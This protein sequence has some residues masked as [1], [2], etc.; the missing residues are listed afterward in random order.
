MKRRL[1]KQFF[2]ICHNIRSTYNV[3]SI[4]R[5]ADAVRINK[6]YLCGYTSAPPNEKIAKVA[7][8]AEK[9]VPFESV[10]SAV[11]LIKKLKSNGVKI[12]ALENNIKQGTRS[13]TKFGVG[14]N[15]LKFKPKFPLALVLGNEVEG[16]PKSILNLA[17]KIIYL[18]M[19]G[20]KES[21]NV[22]VAFGI[23][24]YEIKK[25]L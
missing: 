22:S 12:I 23:A 3:G 24:A 13:H 19:F 2:V 15:Y 16:L 11:G 20:A 25:F 1:D 4:F 7:L 21:L 18:P 5:T 17:D 9:T 8:G 6:I 14:V 10:K